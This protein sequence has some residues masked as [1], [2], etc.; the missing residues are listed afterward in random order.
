MANNNKN[1]NELVNDDDETTAE[2]EVL[3][4]Q[5]SD[6]PV[7]LES[8][9]STAR[10]AKNSEEDVGNDA[11]ISDLQSDLKER[12]E[13]INRLQFDMTQ[14][15]AKWLGLDTEIQEREKVTRQLNI[16]LAESK[17]SL[18]SR[19]S[20]LD[21]RDQKIKA[22]QADIRERNDAYRLLQDNI[23]TLNKFVAAST[24]GDAQ[25]DEQ[26]LA[27][28]AGQLASS[29]MSIR[30]LQE[31]NARLEA[32]ADQLRQQIQDRDDEAGSDEH[33][34]E[35]LQARLEEAGNSI[36]AMQTSVAQADESNATLAAELSSLH[37]AHADE[38]RMIRFE[39]GEAQ[40][41]VSQHELT[42][43]QLASDL[44]DTR[45]LRLELESKL[46]ETEESNKSRI[47]VLEKENRK[48]RHTI[49]DQQQKLDTKSEA[50]TCL[51]SEL[52]K[53]TRPI[54]SISETED[55]SHEIDDRMSERTEDQS[56][57]AKDRVTR[58]LI[59]SIDDQE[60]RFPLFNDRLTIG[61]SAQND[62]QLKVSHI[63]RRHAVVVTEEGSTRVIDWG[64]KNGVYVNSK[65]ITEH[66]LKNG[67]LV[68][69]G[70]AEFRYEERPKRDAQL[71]NRV[72]L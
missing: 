40:E 27:I 46:S 9:A 45:S 68:T 24:S 8:D 2:Q 42:T 32:Y 13:T 52:A 60:L 56:P 5:P 44:V 3:V 17:V 63:S 15:R 59:G 29:E 6:M 37:S 7:E 38:I 70:T 31:R 4:P 25:Q 10:L 20:L 53:K 21:K 23:D 61:R 28:Q 36:N 43:E 51:L 18:K 1:N 14:L 62:I 67:D 54:E 57:A 22:L 72:V 64:S 48:H 41:T 26:I 65:R 34:S 30:E 19:K 58:V 33:I 71:P 49:R 47:E 69:V 66:V 12:S 16:E 11:A 50:I 39:L 55:V 35:Y